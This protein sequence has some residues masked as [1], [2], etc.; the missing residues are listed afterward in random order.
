[1]FVKMNDGRAGL[2]DVNILYI[3]NYY[4][5]YNNIALVMYLSI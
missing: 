4:I 3:D 1:M 2:K 5:Q